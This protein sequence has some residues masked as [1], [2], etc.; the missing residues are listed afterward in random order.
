MQLKNFLSFSSL[1]LWQLPHTL[2]FT[3]FAICHSFLNIEAYRPF[4]LRAIMKILYHQISTPT[5]ACARIHVVILDKNT[6]TEDNG[7][8]EDNCKHIGVQTNV[9]TN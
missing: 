6:E 5:S 7:I 4:S 9:V 1:K 8:L 3:S 2:C